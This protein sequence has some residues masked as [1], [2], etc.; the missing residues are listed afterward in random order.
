MDLETIKAEIAQRFDLLE[1]ERQTLLQRINELSQEQLRLQGEARLVEK[2]VNY[3][4]LKERAS[5]FNEA[6]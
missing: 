2:L 6:S 3:P 5:Q 1:K 4:S